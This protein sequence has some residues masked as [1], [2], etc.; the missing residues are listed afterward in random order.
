MQQ[1]RA[2]KWVDLI[3]NID[4]RVGDDVI[5]LN[6]V[7]ASRNNSSTVNSIR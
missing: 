3:R 1:W 5:A 4:E 6:K 2:H 7:A